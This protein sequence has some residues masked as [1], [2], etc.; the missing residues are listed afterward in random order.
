MRYYHLKPARED[1]YGSVPSINSV[2]VDLD[3][4]PRL[5]PEGGLQVPIVDLM[6][7]LVGDDEFWE[8]PVP[9]RIPIQKEHNGPARFLDLLKIYNFASAALVVS[10]PFREVLDRFSLP[11]HAVYEVET[12]FE[13]KGKKDT[14]SYFIYHF[15]FDNMYKDLDFSGDRLS[16]EKVALSSSGRFAL[17]QGSCHLK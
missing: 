12:Y 15:V 2:N 14:R 13:S 3:F 17:C 11:P 16:F 6:Q 5:V 8:D 10:Q 7:G 9:L 1:Q 4:S